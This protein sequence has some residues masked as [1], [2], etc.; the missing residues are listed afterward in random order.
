MK[1]LNWKTDNTLQ[2]LYSTD[3][4]G[5]WI[6]VELGKERVDRRFIKP[7]IIFE[8]PSGSA[9]CLGNGTSRSGYTTEKFEKTNARKILRYYNVMYGC[10]AIYR[11]WQPDF[12]V[13]T[14]QLLASKM[15]SDFYEISFA[16]QEIMRRYKGMNLIPGASRLDAGSAAVY[17]AAF[18][19][20]KQIFLYGYDGQQVP[21]HNNNIYAGTE[22]Y[23]PESEMIKD[24]S[25]IF[26]LKNI[27]QTYK[28]VKFYRVTGNPDDSYRPLLRFNNYK[29]IT[30]REFI[31]LADL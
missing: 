28:D 16:P 11:D 17:L 26:N 19:G 25:W 4:A 13:I 22:F 10:N 6:N 27:I 31:S 29:P 21:D 30:F 23:P 1:S 5:E 18:H 8:N 15:P 24:S 2:E 12:L 9:I 20:A 7:N 3:Y 14:N